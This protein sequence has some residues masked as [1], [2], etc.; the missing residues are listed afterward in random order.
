MTC[1]IPIT[2][3]RSRPHPA[4]STSAGGVGVGAGAGEDVAADGD[5]PGGGVAPGVVTHGGVA[6]GV[7][8]DVGAIGAGAPGVVGPGGVANFVRTFLALLSDMLKRAFWN[9][10]NGDDQFISL[11]I[12]P[13]CF[14][15][16]LKYNYPVLQRKACRDHARHVH[17]IDCS[18]WRDAGE[19]DPGP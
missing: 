12:I 17:N 18:F 4:G 13:L 7:A 8:P 19:R 15:V 9:W 16:V 3:D 14:V 5:A 6:P 1:P 10:H 2:P 11:L